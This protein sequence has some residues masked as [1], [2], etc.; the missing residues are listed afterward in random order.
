LRNSIAFKYFTLLIH[1]VVLG[2]IVGGCANIVPPSG[3]PRDVQ[4]PQVKEVEPAN[5][6]LHFEAKKV[7]ITFNEFFN[8]DNPAQQI[9]VSPP[10]EKQPDYVISGKKLILKFRG[11]FQSNTTYNIDFGNALKDYNEGNVQ[12][13]FKYVF[14]TGD[15]IDSASIGGRLIQASDNLAGEDYSVML[16]TDLSDSIVFKSKP[17]Y[18]ARTNKEGLFKIENIKP[19]TYKLVALKDQDY[20]YLYDSEVEQIAF[21]DSFINMYDSTKITNFLLRGFV[22]EP[23]KTMLLDVANPQLGLIKFIYNRPIQNI[24]FDADVYNKNDIAIVNETKDTISY[25]YA[26]YTKNNTVFTITTNG[27]INDTVSKELFFIKENELKDN[28]IGPLNASNILAKMKEKQ[29]LSHDIFKPYVLTL[30]RPF[31]VVDLARIRLLEDTALKEVKA[32]ILQNKKDVRQLELTYDWQAGTNYQIEVK[33]GALLDV[34]GQENETFLQS[35][36]TMSKQNYGNIIIHNKLTRDNFFLLQILNEKGQKIYQKNIS[37]ND[38]DKTI[39]VSNLP[40]G[41]YKIL[42]VEDLNQNGRWDTGNYLLHRQAEKIY[43][44][45]DKVFLKPGWDADIDVSL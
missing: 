31:K 21:S 29:D 30:T 1:L 17:L 13:S 12:D 19:G 22:E 37:L 36:M 40:S 20:D 28:A 6:S 32:T 16:Y 26:D 11:S 23:S 43:T 3:G 14:S 8:L 10:M 39:T 33:K 9:I 44:F 34:F 7:T 5:Y 27:N 38:L 35:F 24:K 18:V 2:L 42:V 15:F 45:G 41:Y 4:K 25:Y